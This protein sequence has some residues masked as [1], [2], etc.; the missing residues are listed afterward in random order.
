[1]TVKWVCTEDGS[2]STGPCKEYS[3]TAEPNFLLLVGCWVTH[4]AQAV[5]MT[6]TRTFCSHTM[7]QK[8]TCVWGRGPWVQMKSR[9][10]R[11][12]EGQTAPITN[13]GC[14]LNVPAHLMLCG[15]IT[16]LCSCT[17]KEEEQPASAPLIR[18]QPQ[19]RGRE[20]QN[21]GGNK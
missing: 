20:G 19:A 8:S 14:Q 2:D 6:M 9:S 17:L 15:Q 18:K 12:A 16:W 7:R 10:E 21:V 3:S 11:N 5:T 13:G 4:M 1:M